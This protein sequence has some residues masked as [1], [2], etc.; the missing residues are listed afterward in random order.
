MAGP[1]GGDHKVTPLRGG[2]AFSGLVIGVELG[3]EE[4]QGGDAA[5]EGKRRRW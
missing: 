2:V 4:Q 5:G 3:L 1:T